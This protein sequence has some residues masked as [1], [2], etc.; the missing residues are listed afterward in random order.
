MTKDIAACEEFMEL[1][2]V[3][4]VLSAAIHI[5]GVPDL[6]ELSTRILSS[7]N[8]F[9]AATS[10]VKTLCSEIATISFAAKCSHSSADYVQEYANEK[11]SLG[12]LLLEFKD[13]VREG[14][15]VRV[16]QCW[17][18]FF[19]FF[20]GTG[21]KNYCLE[22]FNFLMQYHYTLTPRCAS[23]AVKTW[24]WVQDYWGAEAIWDLSHLASHL[25]TRQSC[26]KSTAIPATQK[27]EHDPLL[28]QMRGL[29]LSR[30]TTDSVWHYLF[31]FEVPGY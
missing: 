7:G 17:K 24:V 28:G 18:S 26:P 12:L 22:A 15:G 1:I 3:A 4:H 2:T 11:L 25:A 6:A 8:Q 16:L 13:A 10:I 21:H 27:I 9:A 23:A 30:A 31:F 14:D 29:P 19:L 20:R 5:T